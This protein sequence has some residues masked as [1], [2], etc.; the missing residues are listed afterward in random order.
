MSQKRYNSGYQNYW[1]ILIDY[2]AAVAISCKPMHIRTNCIYYIYIYIF[3]FHKLYALIR[4]VFAEMPL[5]LNNRLTITLPDP[6]LEYLPTNTKGRTDH[7][8]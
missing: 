3:F 4:S 5:V 1:A 8:L 7:P 6:N 2:I